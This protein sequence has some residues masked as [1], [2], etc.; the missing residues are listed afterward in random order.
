MSVNIVS[1]G[2]RAGVA[3]KKSETRDLVSAN[4]VGGGS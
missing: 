1:T 4:L 3:D 2:L